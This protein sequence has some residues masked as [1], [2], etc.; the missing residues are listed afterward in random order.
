MAKKHKKVKFFLIFIVLLSIFLIARAVFFSQKKTDLLAEK[1]PELIGYPWYPT[2]NYVDLNN[3]TDSSEDTVGV[4]YPRTNTP[5]AHGLKYDLGT[6][7]NGN[8]S[9]KIRVF[10]SNTAILSSAGVF[11]SK[12]DVNWINVENITN[13]ENFGSR[14]I[15]GNIKLN[16]VKYV[17]VSGWANVNL[18]PDG[19]IRYQAVSV[20]YLKYIAKGV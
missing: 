19:G 1:Q 11:V 12:D 18:D 7:Y 2:N 9:Y 6:V 13:P 15:E 4:F 20:Y 3:I 17:M 10:H 14:V 8:L 16:G 5:L